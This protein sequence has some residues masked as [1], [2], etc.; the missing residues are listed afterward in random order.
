M[1]SS[2]DTITHTRKLIFAGAARDL[3][4]AAGL[5]QADVGAEL[6]VHSSTVGRW[7]TGSRS[8]RG[9]AVF[10]YAEFLAELSQITEGTVE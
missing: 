4:R 8:P 2:I 10:R 5:T 1:T 7:E 9:D 3:R 6:G